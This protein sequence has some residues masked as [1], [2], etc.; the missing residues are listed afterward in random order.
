MG[1][2]KL[3]ELCNHIAA[4]ECPHTTSPLPHALVYIRTRMIERGILHGD[5]FAFVGH[6]TRSACVF[7][8][9]RIH[10][11]VLVLKRIILIEAK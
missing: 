8:K 10:L 11:N 1:I 2:F 7:K 5:I 3:I 4:I 6:K 9:A